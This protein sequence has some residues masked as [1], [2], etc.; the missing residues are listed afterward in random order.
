MMKAQPTARDL[1]DAILLLD[2]PK[3]EALELSRTTR[4]PASYGLML[5]LPVTLIVVA[6]ALLVRSSSSL[7]TLPVLPGW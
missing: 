6:F 2:A 3:R 7:P 5:V 4:T 1:R